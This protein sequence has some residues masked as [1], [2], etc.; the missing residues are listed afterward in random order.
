MSP[1]NAAIFG[2]LLLTLTVLPCQAESR[3]ESTPDLAQNDPAAALPYGGAPYCGPVAVSNALIWLS[4]EGYP[5]LFQGKL[6][7]KLTARTQGKLVAHLALYM[8]TT[9]SM[10]TTVNG[11]LKGVERYVQ[12]RGYRIDSLTYSG[13]EHCDPKYFTG[14][15]NASPE[16]IIE[17]LASKSAVW[18][19]VGWYRYV[20]GKL[21]YR[22][23]AGHWVTAVSC[24]RLPEGVYE[25]SIKDS[26]ARSGIEPKTEK[27]LLCPLKDGTILTS[28][29]PA[30]PSRGSY[31]MRGEL[32]IKKGATDGILDGIVILKM[33]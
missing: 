4:K 11:F 7:D 23:F 17:A 8:N 26:A 12:S 9:R 10:G 29:A 32:K 30:F 19:K 16:T 22:R 14:Q 25:V 6:N 27:V 28:W 18:L 2:L 5:N 13:W 31:A 1:S 20:P 21:E 24:R 15:K 3:M 33:R